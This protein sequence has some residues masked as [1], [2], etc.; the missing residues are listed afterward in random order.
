VQ[1]NRAVPGIA[2]A[3]A[4]HR[5]LFTPVA[6]R[7]M[8][9]A[10]AARVRV[11]PHLLSLAKLFVPPVVIVALLRA[12]DAVAA[13]VVLPAIAIFGALDYLDGV[14]A[15]GQGRTSALGRVLD[16]VTDLPLLLSL[17]WLCAEALPA[18]PL[19]LRLVLDAALMV[20]YA[21]GRGSTENRVRTVLSWATLLA[22]LLF[23]R[24]WLPALVSRD[25]VTALLWVSVLFSVTVLLYNLRVISRRNLADALSL[26]NLAT[27]LAGMWLA[28]HGR[29]EL[30]LV[31]LLAGA[32]LDGLDG[33]AARRF[34]GTRLGVIA[35]DV[36]DAVSYGVAPAFALAVTLGGPTGIGLG[37]LFAVAVVARLLFFTLAKRESDPAFFR[38]LPSTAGGLL[39]LAALVLFA[40]HPLVVGAITGAACILMVS[41]DVRHR[42]L[43]RALTPPRAIAAA[44]TSAFLLGLAI[45]T[46][47]PAA[48]AVL[49]AAA[50]GYALYPSAIALARAVRAAATRRA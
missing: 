35:D 46:G 30:S 14:V 17:G 49:L 11:H 3:A 18:A 44:A 7:R 4:E 22:L 12:E 24:G 29:L 6:V 28:A 36:A 1:W 33:A 23:S 31:M 42:H 10:I 45:V 50:L 13:A 8:E 32:A 47:P 26:G 34:G 38:G 41:F 43:G 20:L 19:M 40:G 15:R 37:V 16:R 27:G 21:A 39:V 9:A 48:A 25:I 5:L 2:D